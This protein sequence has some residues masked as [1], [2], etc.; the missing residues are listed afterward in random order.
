[1]GDDVCCVV[2][3]G[4]HGNSSVL[5]MRTLS[6]DLR[7]HHVVGVAG[8]V[9]EMSQ[10]LSAYEGEREGE[11]YLIDEMANIVAASPHD[12]VCRSNMM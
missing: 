6:T 8:T 5:L 3:G 9:V 12:Q 4:C 7:P 1:M 10:L 2:G 11:M